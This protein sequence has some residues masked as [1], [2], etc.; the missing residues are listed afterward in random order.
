MQVCMTS[1]YAEK[2]TED[3][4][5]TT[6]CTLWHQQIPEH[7]KCKWHAP[8]LKLV[9]PAGR[10]CILYRIDRQLVAVRKDRWLI[11]TTRRTR[12]DHN[13]TVAIGAVGDVMSPG[14]GTKGTLVCSHV[15]KSSWDTFL[16]SLFLFYIFSGLFISYIM[17]MIKSYLCLYEG[18]LRS[19]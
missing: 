16:L 3:R 18:C 1:L 19:S 11:S 2:F 12:Q 7:I 15:V 6:G 14:N 17:F 4:D 8:G 13:R 5:C 10:L 9:N